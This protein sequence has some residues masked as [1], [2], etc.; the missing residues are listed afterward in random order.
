LGTASALYRYDPNTLTL[1]KSYP[2]ALS[3]STDL[4]S[5]TSPSSITLRKDLP[6]GRIET[7][8]QFTFGLTSPNSTAPSVTTTGTSKGIQSVVQGPIPAMPGT[9]FTVTES[10]ASGSNSSLDMYTTSW[11]CNDGQSGTLAAGN[12]TVEV[13]QSGESLLCTI[14]NDI[15]LRGALAWNKVG[16]DTSDYLP[17]SEW[18]L[19]GIDT[20]DPNRYTE[21]ITDCTSD[22]CDGMLDQDNQ[23]GRFLVNDLLYGSYYLTEFKAP[24]GYE[25]DPSPKLV[26]VNSNYTFADYYYNTM[27]PAATVTLGKG[28]VG[29][30]GA[31]ISGESVGWTMQTELS[32]APEGVNIDYAGSSETLHTLETPDGYNAYAL[33]WTIT[34][35]DADSSTTVV[36][37]E[38]FTQAQ[39]KAYTY[40]SVSCVDES[41]PIENPTVNIER[42]T[43]GDD[44]SP[45][46]RVTVTITG[47]ESGRQILCDFT[48]QRKP[49][50]LTWEKR[51]T[52]D[53][54]L[55][56]GGSVWRFTRNG[57][58]YLVVADNVGSNAA[59]TRDVDPRPGYFKVEGMEWGTYTPEEIESPLG[60]V[61]ETLDETITIDADNLDVVRQFAI[62]NDQTTVPPI[63]LTGGTGKD[64]FIFGGVA[65]LVLAGLSETVRRLRRSRKGSGM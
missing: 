41:G 32:N 50:S 53:A 59:D 51:G 14:T 13:M 62:Y 34:F 17:G 7:E 5:C 10:M 44:N 9:E 31:K 16:A 11:E 26:V 36:V 25:I 39:A 61:V 48:N 18:T 29:V 12:N 56:L 35:P 42:E 23:P 57:E 2:G 20:T 6:S 22:T 30:L 37:S 33:P 43:A 3:N 65:L 4:A 24:E 27:V 58:E 64:L 54:T 47:V 55:P 45:I 21:K 38:T 28:V 60:Y 49:G 8:D 52:D 46:V 40:N 19:E 63:P 1:L 15:T